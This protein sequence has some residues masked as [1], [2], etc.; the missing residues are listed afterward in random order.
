MYDDAW[1]VQVRIAVNN[2]QQYV[3]STVADGQESQYQ[4]K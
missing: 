2:Q 1:R 4:N 3:R